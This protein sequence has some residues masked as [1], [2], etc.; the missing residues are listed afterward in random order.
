MHLF[1]QRFECEKNGRLFRV[2]TNTKG[3][4]FETFRI[5]PS[6]ANSSGN[7]P[8]REQECQFTSSVELLEAQFFSAQSIVGFGLGAR[9][10]NGEN[11]VKVRYGDTDYYEFGPLPRRQSEIIYQVCL[12]WFCLS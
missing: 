2:S 7:S 3:I 5:V 8:Y 9:D 6:M 11:R 12:E 1:K 4:L 10:T